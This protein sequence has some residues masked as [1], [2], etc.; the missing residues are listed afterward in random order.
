MSRT[1]HTTKSIFFKGEGPCCGTVWSTHVIEP[2]R[3]TLERATEHLVDVVTSTNTQTTT[4]L[5]LPEG[6]GRLLP[7]GLGFNPR[8][9]VMALPRSPPSLPASSYLQ[10]LPWKIPEFWSASG[11]LAVTSLLSD[12]L[13]SSPLLLCVFFI[14]FF[15]CGV[16][17]FVPGC[18]L[19]IESV[20][21]TPFS[22]V[23]VHRLP[24]AV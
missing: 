5:L 10:L 18:E 7:C 13:P 8:A 14:P 12:F 15:Y 17:I 1:L 22:E 24:W 16:S 23:V 11:R 2:E 4:P 9:M 6:G 3:S 21:R 19:C 20:S